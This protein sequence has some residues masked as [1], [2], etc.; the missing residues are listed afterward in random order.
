ME[1]EMILRERRDEIKGKERYNVLYKCFNEV[2]YVSSS[3][4]FFHNKIFSQ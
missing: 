4:K 1:R 2:N 3:Y